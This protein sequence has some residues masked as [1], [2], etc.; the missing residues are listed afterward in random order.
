MSQVGAKRRGF[1]GS[2]WHG[3]RI[4]KLHRQRTDK[5]AHM[6]TPKDRK[7][8]HTA[9]D[10]GKILLCKRLDTNEVLSYVMDKGFEQVVQEVNPLFDTEI[11][12]SLIISRAPEKFFEFPLS[13]ILNPAQVGPDAE[14]AANLLEINYHRSDQKSEV[15]SKIISAVRK[16]SPRSTLLEDVRLVADE[17]F[18]NS[19]YNAP[20][21]AQ[22]KVIERSEKI[23]LDPAQGGRFLLGADAER[24]LIVCEDSFGSLDL[25]SLVVR[26][27]NCLESGKGKMINTGQGGAGIG[28]YMIFETCV[29]LYTAVDKSKKTIFACLFPL[30]SAYRNQPDLGKNIHFFRR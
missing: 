11:L 16:I 30:R 26:M 19:L 27:K 25:D 20:F 1:L 24:V 12:S 29:S 13:A 28:T 3:F 7:L 15:L 6:G 10:F 2:V 5:Y 18:S 17:L 4:V 23:V 21:V 8:D 9:V 14:K 22:N